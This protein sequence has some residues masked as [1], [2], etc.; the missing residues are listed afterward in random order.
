MSKQSSKNK[1]KMAYKAKPLGY[2]ARQKVDEALMA[3]SQAMMHLS[4]VLTNELTTVEVVKMIGIAIKE[5]AEVQRVLT[6]VKYL[7]K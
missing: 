2:N 7:D 6:E 5:S 3:N 1:R 4:A